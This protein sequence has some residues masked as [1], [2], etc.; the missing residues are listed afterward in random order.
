MKKDKL[1]KFF[2]ANTWKNTICLFLLAGLICS[3][4][5]SWVNVVVDMIMPTKKVTLTV[6]ETDREIN[7]IWLADDATGNNLF[8]SC[9]SSVD[10]S[11]WEYRDAQEYQYSA[12]TLLSYGDNE[13]DTF[14]ITAPVKSNSYLMFWRHMGCGEVTI[15]V[16][17]KEYI[18]DTQSEIG[19][20]Y[21]FYPFQDSYLPFVAR[22]I[23][24]AILIAIAFCALIG[25]YHY[26]TG[27][28]KTCVL[29]RYEFKSWYIFPLWLFLYLY[30]VV[31]YRIGIP[32]Y[33]EFGDQGYYWLVDIL[34]KDNFNI[35][36]SKWAEYVANTSGLWAVRGYWCNIFTSLAKSLGNLLIID[37]IYFYLLA[38]TGAIV[39]VN[40]YVFPELHYL[41]TEKRAN[42][43]QVLTTLLLVVFFWNGC[44]TAITVDI[45]GVVALLTGIV[46]AF[47]SGKNKKWYDL[48]STGLFL[49]IACNYRTA[50]QYGIYVM[51]LCAIV[52][53]VWKSGGINIAI[54]SLKQL[55][56]QKRKQFLLNAAALIL[57][58]L[59]IA[60]PQ[61]NINKEK[62]HIGFL[63]YDYPGAW[64]T[65]TNPLDTSLTESSAN[66]TLNAGYTGYPI[67]VADE[68][69]FSIK[70]NLYDR[71]DFLQIPQILNAYASSPLNSLQ[72]LVKKLFLAFDTKI[73]ITYP[74]GIPW[75]HSIGEIYSFANYFVLIS[76]LYTL[77]FHKNLH[78]TEK[79]LFIIAFLGLTLPQMFV[80][81]EWRYFLPTYFSFYYLF[82]Y[83]FFDVFEQELKEKTGKYL[84][85]MSLG[86]FLC[87]TISFSVFY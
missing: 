25:I 19:D 80:H 40:C 3:L 50:Y 49:S 35:Y 43:T 77:F 55:I 13:G 69:M 20:L 42:L 28:K 63:P 30:A 51:V 26:F 14:T 18:V 76:A 61:F 85:V 59:I 71:N 68:Q 52:Y 70:D 32:N 65:G 86:I 24:Y 6:N 56:K 57:G 37:P 64:V 2:K 73:N 11:M 74:D 62:G 15:D 21:R 45:F 5:H 1:V 38:P 17:G 48:F 82:A 29:N 22:A 8:S 16:D 54:L 10:S 81:V 39:W 41:A 58:F 87:F 36:S 47:K 23:V 84:T 66:Q 60:I 72:Y 27:R 9:V 78:I 67:V 79:I 31:Q 33:L 83:R 46:F 12:N 4:Q 53:S 34:K 44:V 7:E 75:N